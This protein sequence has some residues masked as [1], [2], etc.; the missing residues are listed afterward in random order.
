MNIKHINICREAWRLYDAWQDA[1]DD[2]PI[3]IDDVLDAHKAYL[4]HRRTCAECTPNGEKYQ[5]DTDKS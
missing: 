1:L 2:R 3:D 5:N 4:E